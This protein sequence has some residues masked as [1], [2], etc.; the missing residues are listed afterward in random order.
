[1]ARTTPSGSIALLTEAIQPRPGRQGWHGGPT[2]VG[3]VRGVTAE[4]ARWKPGP[5]R[6]SIWV[7]TLHIA[8]WKYAVRRLLEGSPRGAFS[9]P[10]SNWPAPPERADELGWAADVALLR[11]EHEQL[12]RA[13][14]RVS[15]RWLNRRPPSSKRWT[16]GELIVGIAMHDAYHT[17]QIQLLKRLWQER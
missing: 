6:K 15:P 1:M 13:A 5:K 12:A 11:A 4:M 3:A 9:R 8:Y 10:P 17:G 7:L 2:P 16:Y 14:S